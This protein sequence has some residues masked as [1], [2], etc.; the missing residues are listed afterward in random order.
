MPYQ[1]ENDVGCDGT[2]EVANE[3]DQTAEGIVGVEVPGT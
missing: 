3:D 2:S 1:G